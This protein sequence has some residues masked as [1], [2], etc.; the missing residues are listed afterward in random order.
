[1]N[2]D[3]EKVQENPTEV[4]EEVKTEGL[5]QATESET[6]EASDEEVV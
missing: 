6:V 5:D 1:M 2:D 4:T 3:Q